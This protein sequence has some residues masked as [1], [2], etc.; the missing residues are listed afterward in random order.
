MH[1]KLG[2]KTK[3][4]LR[5][6]SISVLLPAL[7]EEKNLKPTVERLQQALNVTMDQYELIIINDG[8]S[9]KTGE[10]ADQLAAQFDNIKVKHNS[11]CTGLGN[12]YVQGAELATMNYFSYIPSDNTWPYRSFVEL[13]G[14]MGKADIIT[15][16]SSN[17][18][19][20]PWSR[21]IVS[22]S[23]TKTMNLLFGLDLKYFNGLTI[24]P[25]EYL[26]RRPISTYGFGFQSEALI[27]ALQLGY[28]FI[29]L[30]LPIDERTAGGSKAVNIKNITSVIS[31]IFRM[32]WSVRVSKNWIKN[33]VDHSPYKKNT[34]L[35]GALPHSNFSADENGFKNDDS[36]PRQHAVKNDPYIIVVTGASSGIGAEL[37]K[38]LAEDGHQVF[39]CARSKTKL[40]KATNNGEFAEF[41]VCDVS[42][43]EQVSTFAKMLESKVDRVDVLINCAGKFGAIGSIE[44][45]NSDEWLD[46]IKINLFGPYLTTKKLLNLLKQSKHPRVINFSGGGAFNPFPNFSAYACSKASLVRLTETLAIELAPFGIMV[47]AL[48]PGRIATPAHEAILSAGATLA[49]SAHFKKT[50]LLMT[51]GGASMSKVIDCVRMMLTEKMYGL[52]GKTISANFDPWDTSSFQDSLMDISRSDLYTM[53]RMN[54]VNLPE[55]KLKARMSTAWA[56][57]GIKL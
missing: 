43:E 21:R 28:S 3:I 35:D 41:T 34:L 46:T 25:I 30:G 57:H 2:I 9:D 1:N 56:K 4:S 37:I 45:A 27:K 50:Q 33:Q 24:Y 55:G 53:C 23:F 10:V 51:E 36:R 49:G 20:R 18:G 15:S 48:A 26:K 7:N 32:F 6:R 14:N 39:A 42:D 12:V 11:L 17:P 38:K 5:E 52:T 16:F 31:T 13:F 22:K 40:E 19:V 29:E 47:N 8:S 44:V 54:I